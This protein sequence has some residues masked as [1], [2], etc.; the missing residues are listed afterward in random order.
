MQCLIDRLPKDLT[1]GQQVK[2]EEF[3]RSKAHI[4]SRSQFDIG[5]TDI[6]R[7]RI[8]TGENMPH[9]EQLRR[10][11]TSQLPVI[12]EHIDQMLRHDVIEPPA[13][14]WS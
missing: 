1:D 11:P 2:A 3:I 7:H 9:Y 14:P 4:F 10:H 5:R 6:L 12:D 8:D 13:S